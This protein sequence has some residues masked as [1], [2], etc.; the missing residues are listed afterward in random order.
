MKTVMLRI[1]PICGAKQLRMLVG[2][3]NCLSRAACRECGTLGPLR[4]TPKEAEDAW[5][6]SA[7]WKML[8]LTTRPFVSAEVVVLQQYEHLP[9]WRLKTMRRDL[10]NQK[11][12][13]PD[14]TPRKATDRI[15]GKA[16]DEVRG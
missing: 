16:V 7:R 15:L 12:G 6:G 11:A 10:K 3:Y 9:D 14:G 5:N 1:C 8:H 2:V 13:F 4:A